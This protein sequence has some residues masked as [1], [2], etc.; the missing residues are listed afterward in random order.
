MWILILSRNQYCSHSSALSAYY[1]QYTAEFCFIGLPIISIIAHWLYVHTLAG[2]ICWKRSSPSS[3]HHLKIDSNL[4]SVCENVHVTRVEVFSK[5]Q[6]FQIFCSFVDFKTWP[7]SFYQT[8]CKT[9]ISYWLHFKFYF[10]YILLTCDPL[11]L[12]SVKLK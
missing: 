1:P 6:T 11:A 8:G 2:V 10:H 3:S 9:T 12:I 4:L 5:R 7:P